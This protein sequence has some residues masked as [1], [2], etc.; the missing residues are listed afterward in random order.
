M[1]AEECRQESSLSPSLTDLQRDLGFMEW[2]RHGIEQGKGGAVYSSMRIP[3]GM[4]WQS[5]SAT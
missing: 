2:A 1:R 4:R 5:N 3:L